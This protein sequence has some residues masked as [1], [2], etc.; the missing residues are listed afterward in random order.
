MIKNLS[1]REIEVLR[2]IALENTTE[3][4]GNLLC[5]SSH[6]AQ[7]HRKNLLSKLAVKN[8]AGLVRRGFELGIL[9]VKSPE[10]LEH[11]IHRLTTTNDQP[12]MVRVA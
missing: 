12:V 1:K 4:I 9:R 2:L 10:P 6:T 3:E 11:S 7:T 8:S 5:I